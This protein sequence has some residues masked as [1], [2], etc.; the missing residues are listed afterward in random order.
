MRT[1]W[2]AW[3]LLL[4]PRRIRRRLAQLVE[5][6]VL[7][8]APNLWQMELGVLRM[9]HRL[10]FR[11]DTVG[12]CTDHPVRPNWRARL[13]DNRLLRFPFLVWERAIAPFDHTGLGVPSWRLVRHLLAAHHDGNQ[14][15][16]DLEILRAE[17]ERLEE[18][19]RQARE[20]VERDTRRGRW[21]KDL[22]VYERYHQ[23]LLEAVETVQGG[24]SLLEQEEAL[25]PDIGF[26]A[27]M[28]WCLAQ[29]ETPGETWKAWR[30]GAFPRSMSVTEAP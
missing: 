8:R 27:A 6:G 1:P 7:E 11:S 2:H 29:P 9:W 3:Y 28:G 14:F 13:L 12:M 30:A 4:R 26:Q 17:P 18:L 25:D 16:Y 23:N 20:I 22:V 21:L 24:A 19:R 15:A 10:V 5:A